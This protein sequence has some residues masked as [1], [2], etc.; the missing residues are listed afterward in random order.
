M[1]YGPIHCT[2]CGAPLPLLAAVSFDCPHCQAHVAVPPRYKHL[3]EANVLE[4]TTHAELEAR[5]AR[6]SR[7]PSRRFDALAIALVLLAPAIAAA[8]WMHGTAHPPTAIDLFTFAIIPAL[9]PGTALWMWSAAIHATVVRFRFVLAARAPKDKTSPP[10]CRE[11]GAPLAATDA[12]IFARC[13]YCGTD[14]LV[15]EVS[16][17][18]GALDEALRREVKTIA[19]AITALVYRRR[20]VVAGVAIVMIVLAAL[21]AGVRI[22]A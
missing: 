3:Y 11:C 2:H 13:A 10:C 8:T 22:A 17:A 21:I 6:V 14:S 4:A 1:S 12:A 20:L 18:A 5:Y 19:E 15:T 7:V 16:D 9:V